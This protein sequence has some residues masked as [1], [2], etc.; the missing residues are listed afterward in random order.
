MGSMQRQP[1]TT[2]A[3]RF[4]RGRRLDRN[5]LRRTSDRAETIVFAAIVLAFLVA[6]P[7]AALALGGWAH[8]AA[9]RAEAGQIASRHLVTAV[10]LAVP[11]K[12]APG[13]ASLITFTQARWT[14]PDGTV[15]TGQLPVP[16]GTRPGAAIRVWTT[17]NGQLS[18]QPMGPGQVATLAGLGAIG[19]ATGVAVLLCWASAVARW[20]LD[21]RRMAAW[22]ADWRSTAPRWTTRA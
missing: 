16:A 12:P 7:L 21:K 3:G 19:G 5:P 10:V 6:V 18:E 1:R 4:I 11:A 13:S 20:L 22:E 17:T 2:V 9:Q 14:A 15:V 8:A